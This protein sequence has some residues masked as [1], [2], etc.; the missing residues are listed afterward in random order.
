MIKR[1][2]R[3]KRFIKTVNRGKVALD[4]TSMLNELEQLHAAKKIRVVTYKEVVRQ[5]QKTLIKSGLQ[6]QSYRS[7][8]VEI[9]M[10][11]SRQYSVLSE[12]KDVLYKYILSEHRNKIPGKTKEE[13]NHYIDNILESANR[14]I[15][16]L[17]NVIEIAD[18]VI[19]D[20]DKAAWVISQIV[21][22]LEL[23]TRPERNI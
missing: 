1:D 19:D 17:E 10:K 21:K 2:E 16:K 5:G 22:T 11:A 8:C 13:R 20:C 7:R 3:V 9:K 18:L 4:T 15:Y 12:H 6:N 23:S 14:L